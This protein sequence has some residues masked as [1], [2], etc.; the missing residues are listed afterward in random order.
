MIGAYLDFVVH[1]IDIA[2]GAVQDERYAHISEE[3]ISK[4]DTECNSVEEW[5][6]A[7]TAKNAQRSKADDVQVTCAAINDARAVCV[8]LL[9]GVQRCVW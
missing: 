3:E 6:N 7:E 8:S 1:G 2:C 4:V 5:L 9:A